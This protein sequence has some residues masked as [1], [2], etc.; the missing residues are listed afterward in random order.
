MPPFKEPAV[1]PELSSQKPD[2]RR[3]SKDESHRGWPPRATCSKNVAACTESQSSSYLLS[4]CGQVRIKTLT[5][6][7]S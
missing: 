3:G 2:G 5:A 1:L 4:L 7:L 6:L